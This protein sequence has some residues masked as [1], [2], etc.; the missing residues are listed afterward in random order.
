MNRTLIITLCAVL[1]Q[2]CLGQAS[3][4]HRYIFSDD[5]TDR[6][7]TLDGTVT[8]DSVYTLAPE[9][10]SATPP[11]AVSSAP[12]SALSVGAEMGSK[13]S[14][15]TV[16]RDTFEIS[17]TVAF[18]FKP[19]GSAFG[20]YLA[21]A[22]LQNGFALIQ[23]SSTETIRVVTV[24]AE[25]SGVDLTYSGADTDWHFFAVSW[26][27]VS[28]SATVYLDDNSH[29]FTFT[30]G[31]W[32]PI[33]LR[34]GSYNLADNANNLV[35]QFAGLV[36]DV[37]IY[38]EVLASEQIG[39][40]RNVPGFQVPDSA[41][42][43]H[44]YVFDGHV[45]DVL[46]GLNGIPTGDGTY[47]ELPQYS[48]DVPAGAV[49]GGPEKSVELGVDFGSR[50]S[51][52]SIDAAVINTN[53]GSY[54]FWTKADVLANGR[55]IFAPLPLA[56]G[57]FLMG[58]SSS[59]IKVVAGDDKSPIYAAFATGVWHHVAVTW[60]NP[61]GEL[62]VYLDGSLA[63]ATNFLSG[64][65][66]PTT[67]R[68]G[69]FS[70]TDDDGQLSNQYEG[71]LYDIQIYDGELTGDEVATLYQQP[72][73]TVVSE[74]QIDSQ[75]IILPEATLVAS[76]VVTNAPYFA[77]PS[78]L[79]DSSVA[80][81]SALDVAAALGGGVVF[82]PPGIY[83]LDG[84]LSID[85]GV[86]LQGAGGSLDD[87][88]LLA[89]AGRSDTNAAPF[90]EAESTEVGIIDLCIYYPEQAPDDIQPYP[91]T[92]RT[93]GA[94]T[95]RNLLLVN[96][97]FGL[98]FELINASVVENIRG[99]VL[100]RGIFAPFSSEFSWMRDIHFSNEIWDAADRDALDSYTR[101][102][103]IGLEMQR[104]DGMALDGFSA[105]D[106]MLPVYM[107]P[108]PD[109]L[110]NNNFGFGGVVHEF[111]E[112]RVEDGWAPWYHGMHYGNLDLVPEAAG[113]Q[114][115]FAS[116]PQPV[117]TDM[118]IDVTRSPYAALGNG[119]A[120]DTFSIQQALSAAGA[121]GGGTVYLPHG[122]YKVTAPLT[123][124]DGVELRGP[125]GTGKAREGRGICTIAAWYGHDT[126]NPLTDT[127]LITLGN[128]AGVR[129]FSILHPQQPYDVTQIKPYPYDIRGNGSNCWVVDM[130]LVNA[131][132][133]IDLASN[134]NDGFLVRDI[135]A[136]AYYKGIDVGGGSVGGRLERLAFS[137]GPAA[138]SGWFSNQ[139]TEETKAALF[140]FVEENSVY[141]SFGASS[142]LTTWG[143]VGFL[144][145]IQCRFYDQAGQ[146]T[147][148]AE[149]WMSVFDVARRSTIVA[150]QGADISWY[151]FWATGRSTTNNWLEADPAFA[152]PL[153]V[154]GKTIHQP[155]QP[156]PLDFTEQQVS[157][158][159][160]ISL[161]FGKS[162]EADQSD[163]GSLPANAVDRDPRTLWE[164][165]ASSVLEVDLG[166]VMNIDN[167]AVE[168]ALFDDP[169]NQITRAELHVSTDGTNFVSVATNTTT[170]AYW[171]SAPLAST[172]ARYAR[173]VAES[174]SGP[175]KISSFNL[176]NTSTLERPA[177]D[178]PPNLLVVFTDQQSFDMLGCYGNTQMH[179]PN[180][181]RLASDGVRFEYCISSTPVCTPYRGMLLSGMHP[182]R[183]G[184]FENDVNM[185][186][187]NGEYFAEVLRDND[188]RTGYVGKWHLY[189]GDRARPVP[190]GLYRYGFDDVFLS[191]NVS[192]DF[193]G[194]FYY[195]Q[196]TG[197]KIDFPADEW[198]V[199]SQTDQAVEFIDQSP[200]NQPWA[201]FT[202]WHPPHDHGGGYDAPPELEAF[203][204]PDTV[205]LRSTMTDSPE[206]RTNFAGYMSMI[207]GCDFAFGR[208]M[209]KL[210]AE[211]I[212]DNTIIVFTSDHGDLHGAHGRPWAKSFPED[213][214]VR[215]PLIIRYP[216]KLRS[217]VSELLVGSLDL[218]PTLLGLMDISAPSSCDGQNLT[219]HLLAEDD[220]AVAS[221][222]LMNYA[223]S[224]R[225]VFTKD[226][227]YSELAD[228]STSTLNFDCLYDRQSDPVQA[229]N[230]FDDPTYAVQQQQ[231]KD[232]MQQWLDHFDDPFI[233]SRIFDALMNV[234]AATG[235][236][237]GRPVDIL[238][239][240]FENRTSLA[241]RYRLEGDVTDAV[242][243][244]SVDGAATAGATW[245]EAPLY[246]SDVPSGMAAGAPGQSLEVGM[247]FGSKNSGFA[248]DETVISTT[249]GSFSLWL[250]ADRIDSYKTYT[251]AALPI[252][253]GIL[254][255]PVNSTTMGATFGGDSRVSAPFTTGV[256]HHAV[257]TWDNSDGAG[258]FY[259]DGSL[260]GATNFMP[261]TI[262]PTYVNV[263]GYNLSDRAEFLENQFEG[264]L[265][266]LQF[267][268]IAL[269][270]DDV[271]CLFAN[272]GTRRIPYETWAFT[273]GLKGNELD[274][275]DHDGLG[276]LAEFA[277]GRDPNSADETEFPMFGK[278]G[279]GMTYIYPRRTDGELKYWL[280]TST[281]LVSGVWTN[282]GTSELPNIGNAGNGFETVT[283]EISTEAA[284]TFIR[285]RVQTK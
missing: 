87:T 158:Y 97:Y 105:A 131:W 281:N 28:G 73:G 283:N 193:D 93:Q 284:Q 103:L 151:G 22:G 80:I 92:I 227:T 135:W 101:Q 275:P 282:G 10:V 106:A 195:D 257:V 215:V 138:E 160:E 12:T 62:L 43:K 181:D 203:Y 72:G 194:G 66:A 58:Q 123:V 168:S 242:E 256:W 45:N 108:N 220:D 96:S 140:D 77:D 153:K 122:T 248:L 188:Y 127:A 53:A 83:R 169:A 78:G 191:D 263:G 67:V 173:L 269:S 225:G 276:N 147:Q 40:L 249:S 247:S 31:N 81:Q 213:E 185:L 201:L 273:Y 146:S 274:D 112:V 184:A 214:S 190:A 182:L 226:F 110:D 254:L 64:S 245:L 252:A 156:Q 52:F 250:K 3:L 91:A 44:R 33:D 39:E 170:T 7:G 25:N 150:E 255:K 161:T 121:A 48:A 148:D 61:E 177:E 206:V 20:R 259:L 196:F 192:L 5:A 26:N 278:S 102:N 251:V 74:P 79:Q 268:S 264:H 210:R 221:V 285:L 143:L 279:S 34:L 198:V 222:P 85:Y 218:M 88:V 219:P 63:G 59:Q 37:Q 11:N 208:L 90:I 8:T 230:M 42:L 277:L 1:L 24:G 130:M 186:P 235:M 216:E 114:Y 133:G 113:K 35:N 163:A 120:D 212:D 171:M 189:G 14:G 141:Y 271:A 99:T 115:T 202:S 179:T 68:V 258:S 2:A 162:A 197:E 166:S 50:K 32:D 95:L 157:F 65:I 118:F 125:V 187:G 46:G 280:E 223:P 69:S 236:L 243:T 137:G 129:G 18:W 56:D 154:Y 117:R 49:E 111:P 174:A 47:T 116:V 134:R 41:R 152:G 51:G 144:P 38:D 232:Q 265:Y 54:S 124:P 30:P 70:L 176:F 21:N 107:Q 231:L 262:A 229:V 178:T 19:D 36:W 149:L 239:D 167:F 267:Y 260:V 159:D 71:K 180:L 126:P 136:T 228:G 199:Y 55:Y 23:L 82:V 155:H 6:I 17:G 132:F 240:Y 217:R 165:P 104:I 238:N 119:T 183:N 237:I 27:N 98:D 211:R 200:T 270:T 209:E 207:T 205:V 261:G 266:D 4:V 100:K 142:N 233:D 253:S 60:N 224:W 272:P 139:K 76:V 86:T 234:D 9:Y 13:K 246:S 172:P 89:Y 84:T 109:Y 128:N 16:S 57:P 145:D 29:H 241:H 15:V 94:A 204:D 164:A 175:L 244:L 75:L